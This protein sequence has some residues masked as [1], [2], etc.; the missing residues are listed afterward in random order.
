MYVLLLQLK[1]IA[2]PIN[3]RFRSKAP[4]QAVFDR[5]IEAMR[6][7]TYSLEPLLIEDDFSQVRAIPVV[8]IEHPG[9]IDVAQD[10]EAQ[11]EM[12]VMQAKRQALMQRTLNADPAL[13]ILANAGQGGIMHS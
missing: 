9:L 5:I 12:G 11:A 6:A 8:Y 13:R 7:D 2:I 3:F 10:Y 1:G 4:A